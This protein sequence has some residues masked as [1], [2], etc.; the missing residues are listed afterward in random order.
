MERA[1]IEPATFGLQSRRITGRHLTPTDRIGMTEPKSGFSPH[2]TRHRLDSGPLAPCSR[3]RRLKRQHD[4]VLLG[5]TG[6]S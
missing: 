2:A 3:R 5:A 6:G 1:G 4:G